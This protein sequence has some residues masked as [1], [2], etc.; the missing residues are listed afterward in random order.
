VAL[1]K[2]YMQERVVKSSNRSLAT[3]AVPMVRRSKARHEETRLTVRRGADG[4][5]DHR[6][7]P[8]ESSRFQP[9]RDQVHAKAMGN[10]EGGKPQRPR[11]RPGVL[12]SGHEA[13]PALKTAR[14]K[15]LR[16][17]N[18]PPA[19]PQRTKPNPCLPLRLF[20]KCSTS[21]RTGDHAHSQSFDYLE[22]PGQPLY[23]IRADRVSNRLFRIV[24]KIAN[25]GGEFPLRESRRRRG[26]TRHAPFVDCRRASLPPHFCL[27]QLGPKKWH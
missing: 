7:H 18:W 6:N 15:P 9:L 13:R 8:A 24:E 14:G 16:G 26:P 19:Q 12:E 22:S 25:A 11:R 17:R 27:H 2:S 1:N 5:E 4:S 21:P 23:H 10:G 20:F 3:S